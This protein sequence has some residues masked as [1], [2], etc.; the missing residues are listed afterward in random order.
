MGGPLGVWSAVSAQEAS[1]GG[2]GWW[3]Y[4]S[5]PGSVGPL[6]SV[7]RS[8]PFLTV[9]GCRQGASVWWVLGNLEINSKKFTVIVL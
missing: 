4:A 7:V 6:T 3:G 9:D 8:G 2:W 5:Q 1:K